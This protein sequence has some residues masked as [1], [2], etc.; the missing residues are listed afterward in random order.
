M[1][2][3]GRVY[4]TDGSYVWVE[5][6]T[7]ADGSNDAVW[8]TTLIQTL[9]LNLNE[10]PFYANYGLPAHQSIIQQVAPDFNVG[11]TQQFFAPRFAALTIVKRSD[12]TPTYDVN[13][14]T[15][16]GV[17]LQASIPV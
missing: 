6:D 3:Y 2:T 1:R 17:K 7:A 15:H 12:P 10:S 5:V 13:V 8:L 14:T 16:Q 4:S 11:L 9:K